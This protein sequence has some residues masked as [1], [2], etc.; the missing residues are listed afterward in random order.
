M[1]IAAAAAFAAAAAPRR[2]AVFGGSFD[3]PT[4]A[5]VLAAA[6]VIQAGAADAC[7]L[8]PCGSRDDKPSLATSGRHRAEMCRLAIAS[9]LVTLPVL[10]SDIEAAGPALPTID[11]LDRLRVEHPDTQFTFVIGEDL[12][13][14]VDTWPPDG[15]KLASAAY[16]FLVVPRAGHALAPADRAA[17]PAHWT[18]ADR[19]AGH[20]ELQLS[21]SEVRDRL[22]RGGPAAAEG[23]VT[24]NVLAYIREHGLYHAQ[25]SSGTS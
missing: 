1:T 2:V 8:T 4:V 22:A 5:H 14:D 16:D 23:L 9:L 19:D 24:P 13:G 12:A 11:L 21:S 25:Q 17:L 18:V 10:V 7:W 6:S 3:P 20:V 15:P